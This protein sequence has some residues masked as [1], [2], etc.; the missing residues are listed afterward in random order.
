M[1][2]KVPDMVPI[3]NNLSLSQFTVGEVDQARETAEKVLAIDPENFH[4]LGNLVRY[5]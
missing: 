3:L 1:L 4:A 2:E 5:N